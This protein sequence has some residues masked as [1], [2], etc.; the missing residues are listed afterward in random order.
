MRIEVFTT[1]D[2]PIKEVF[3]WYTDDHVRNHPRWDPD[4]ELEQI[5]EGAIRVGTMIRRRNTHFENPIE[6]TMEV[7]E[8]EPNQALGRDS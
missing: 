2:R 8:Y 1:V 5:S 6:G 3:H 7:I 4:M